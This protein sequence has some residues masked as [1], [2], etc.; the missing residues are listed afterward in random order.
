M[1]VGWSETKVERELGVIYR[2]LG[3]SRDSGLDPRVASALVYLQH[4][5]VTSSS[6]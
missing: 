5:G 6:Q 4:S 3:L 1:V 2:R